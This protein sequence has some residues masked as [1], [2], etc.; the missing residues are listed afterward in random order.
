MYIRASTSKKGIQGDERIFSG[1]SS[2]YN[3]LDGDDKSLN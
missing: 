2:Y 1:T 3:D